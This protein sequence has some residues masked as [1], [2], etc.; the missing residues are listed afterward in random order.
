MSRH[1]LAT[2]ANFR[3]LFGG[4][5]V[6]M[7]GDQF[8]LVALP[9]LVL[10]LTGDPGALG[11][12]LATM[13]VPRAVFMLIGGAV[14]DHFSARAV[15]LLA[16]GANAVM[17]A[18]LAAMV[19]TGTISMPWVY[20]LALGIGLA[21]AFAYPA[22]TALLPSV[23]DP[24][25]LQQANG[26]MMGMRQLSLFIGPALAGVVIGTGTH[27]PSAG[28]T[29]ADAHGLG[30]AFAIDAAS[31]CASLLSLALIRVPAAEPGPVQHGVFGKLLGG[32]RSI[33]ADPPLR[34]FMFYAAVVSVFVGGPTQVGLPVLADMRLDHGATSLGIVMAASGGGM[35][36]GGLASG[37]VAKLVRGHLGAMILCFD[38]CIGLAL[39]ALAGVHST[40]L[41][42]LLLGLT[43]LFGGIAQITL[44]SWIQRRVPR[45]LLGRTMSVLMFTFLGLGPLSAAG[46]GALLKVISLPTLFVIAGLTLTAIAL[47]CMTSPA[48][49]GIRAQDAA[50]TVA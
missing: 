33:A 28:S 17:V 27:A 37:A 30:W 11:L 5:T 12:V 40:V 42:A 26:S 7:F 22:S 19:L 31:F 23:I 13:A 10:K 49:R 43:G 9:W 38:A 41:A 44:V 21:T 15:L 24:R 4:S 14:V 50:P 47:G 29:L 2:N 16:R 35:L 36:L 20:A 39:V 32:L 18:V 6:S 25:E 3:L 48:L 46:V 8:T 34:A 1:P 45:E